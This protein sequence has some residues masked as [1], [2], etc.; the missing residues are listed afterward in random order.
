MSTADP[1]LDISGFVHAFGT[2][3]TL[4]YSFED[5]HDKKKGCPVIADSLK[6]A[7]IGSWDGVATIRWEGQ[8]R[9]KSKPSKKSL[10]KGPEINT[11]RARLNV[12]WCNGEEAL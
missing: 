5:L 8:K 11:A 3:F 7:T 2:D 9:K 4:V 10:A 12:C 6:S 1:E